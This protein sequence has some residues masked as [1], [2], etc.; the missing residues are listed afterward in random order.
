MSKAI[1]PI[2]AATAAPRWVRPLTGSRRTDLLSAFRFNS[3]SVSVLLS[4]LAISLVAQP[5][6]GSLRQL[7]SALVRARQL[8]DPPVLGLRLLLFAAVLIDA[9]ENQ[10][11]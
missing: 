2:T 6:Q 11:G 4:P 3:R 9:A 1:R 10:M 7:L 8:Q 5:L